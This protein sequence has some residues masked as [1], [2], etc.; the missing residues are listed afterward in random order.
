M[1]YNIFCTCSEVAIE[2]YS[3]KYLFLKYGRKIRTESLEM[4]EAALF[5]PRQNNFQNSSPLYTSETALE[6]IFSSILNNSLA[7]Q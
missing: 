2:R 5:S 7:N 4:L 6:C 1:Q 3:R